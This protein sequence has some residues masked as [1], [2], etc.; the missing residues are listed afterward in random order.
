MILGRKR[1]RRG[2]LPINAREEKS[3]DSRL[4]T[5]TSCARKKNRF[6][7]GKNRAGVYLQKA[8]AAIIKPVTCNGGMR[9][10]TITPCAR[11]G[12]VERGAPSRVASAQGKTAPQA[13]PYDT[14]FPCKKGEPAALLSRYC[15]RTAGPEMMKRFYVGRVL[16]RSRGSFSPLFRVSGVT[17]ER[18]RCR[19]RPQGRS[20]RKR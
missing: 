5:I 11:Y 4:Q 7:N 12:R 6:V 2:R 10:Q 15:R 3:A 19:R 9:R 1:R 14:V 18:A 20:L 16:C 8:R 17:S 13:L